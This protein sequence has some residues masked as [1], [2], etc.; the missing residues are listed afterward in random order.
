MLSN[1]SRWIAATFLG[2]V[3]SA[4]AM[5]LGANLLT[6]RATAAGTWQPSVYLGFEPNGQVVITAHRSEMGT[7]SRTSLPL[8]VAEELDVD[9]KTVRV[10][11]A[12]G[13]TKYGSQNTDGSC[14]VR[15][16]VEAMRAGGRHRAA[17]AGTRRRSEVGRAGRRSVAADGQGDARARPTARA[18]LG[19]LVRDR[20]HAA[21]SRQG[22]T[23]LQEARGIPLHRQGSADPSTSTTS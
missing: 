22:R 7:G 4:G 13:D 3:F 10:E 1:C 19:E 11:Q 20:R 9:W 17:D 6:E 15:D 8:V 2:A 16:F 21:R 12:I 14:S 5:V 18:T 23:A